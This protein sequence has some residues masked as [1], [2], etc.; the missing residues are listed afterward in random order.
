MKTLL[1]RAAATGVPVGSLRQ[2]AGD[3]SRRP[4]AGRTC[5]RCRAACSASSIRPSAGPACR[6][7]TRWVF[8]PRLRWETSR[9]HV[10]MLGTI[11]RLLDVEVGHRAR[12]ERARTTWIRRSR[13]SRDDEDQT[14]DLLTK[15]TGAKAAVEHLKKVHD[16]THGKQA[17]A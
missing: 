2:G 15:T 9:K 5:I 8:W 17:V 1:R 6:A 10:V 4:F 14:L 13:R 11:G 3:A 7:R 12:S 16:L